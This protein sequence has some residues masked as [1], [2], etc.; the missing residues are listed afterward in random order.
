MT[1]SS[2][3]CC[4]NAAAVLAQWRARGAPCAR[5]ASALRLSAQACLPGHACSKP[6]T[7]RSA[8]AMSRIAS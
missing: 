4:L 5:G 3:G 6:G 7:A 2:A 8:L 1:G